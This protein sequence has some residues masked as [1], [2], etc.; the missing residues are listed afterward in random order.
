VETKKNW[1]AEPGL[2]PKLPG[3][4]TTGNGRKNKPTQNSPRFKVTFNNSVCSVP[5]KVKCKEQR[6][7]NPRRRHKSLFKHWRA[8]VEPSGTVTAQWRESLNAVLEKPQEVKKNY[9]KDGESLTHVKHASA[10]E[11]RRQTQT[12]SRQAFPRVDLAH[13][14][15]TPRCWKIHKSELIKHWWFSL[16]FTSLSWV[17]NPTM[18]IKKKPVKSTR[19]VIGVIL[20]GLAHPAWAPSRAVRQSAVWLR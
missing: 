15:R 10:C 6:T 11:A 12:S 5:S 3:R 8:S 7:K 14:W 1:T 20:R 4:G 16:T 18:N 17:D 19:W 9:T 13:I 2:E